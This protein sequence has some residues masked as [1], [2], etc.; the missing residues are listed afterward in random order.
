MTS[1]AHP[2]PD[3]FPQEPEQRYRRLEFDGIEYEH[4]RLAKLESQLIGRIVLREADLKST[5]K[6][7]NTTR[8]PLRR[9]WSALVSTAIEFNVVRSKDD[10][11]AI[12]DR[13]LPTYRPMEDFNNYLA[14]INGAEE[15]NGEHLRTQI[16]R[17][18]QREERQQ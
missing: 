5:Y 4:I 7:F 3:F 14:L 15:F 11:D 12:Q 9:I 16:P 10:L 8:N 13:Q 2:T 18:L 17:N 1:P 6:T